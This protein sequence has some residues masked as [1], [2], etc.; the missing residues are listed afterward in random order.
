MTLAWSNEYEPEQET[1]YTDERGNVIPGQNENTYTPVANLRARTNTG[2]A[3]PAVAAEPQ[4]PPRPILQ[5]LPNIQKKA[6]PV[7]VV[8]GPELVELFGLRVGAYMEEWIKVS[9][10]YRGVNV[11]PIVLYVK[12]LTKQVEQLHPAP[13]VEAVRREDGEQL[14]LI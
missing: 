10:R 13:I 6:E 7:I 9:L 1:L 8:D 2:L 5:L 3:T 14:R 4:A 11:N 12:G